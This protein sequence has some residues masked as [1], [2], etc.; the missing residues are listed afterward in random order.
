MDRMGD[1]E[2]LGMLL[3]T[4]GR[5]VPKHLEALRAFH[6]QRDAE[7][8]ASEAHRVKGAIANFESPEVTECAA[9]LEKAAE[10]QSWEEA[11]RCIG[12][13]ETLLQQLQVQL[14]AFVDED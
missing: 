1:K 8:L 2:L 6:A 4:L 5:N 14:K 7:A 9:V 3:G 13:L 12:Q 10:T 11:Q